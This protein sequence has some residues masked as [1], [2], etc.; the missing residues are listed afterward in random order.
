[1]RALI[2]GCNGFVGRLL[3]AH[4]RAGGAEI[5]GIDRTAQDPDATGAGV[6]LVPGDILDASFVGK[7]LLQARPSHVFH[8]AAVMG[9]SGTDRAGLLDVNAQGTAVVADAVRRHAPGAWLLLASSSAVYGAQ[10]ALPIGEDAPSRPTTP[11]GESKAAAEDAARRVA[12]DGD[13]RLVIARTFNLLGPG[14]SRHLFAGSLAAQIVAAEHGGPSR[15]RVGHLQGKRDYVDV[16][17][18]VR[19]CVSLT[20]CDS[21]TFNVCSEVAR[22]SQELADRMCAHATVPVTLEHDAARLQT[23]DV[24]EQR[25]SFRRLAAATGWAPAI[26]FD[27][28][29][30]DVLEHERRVA[31]TAQ[32]G[33]GNA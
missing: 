7:V 33:R 8:M 29:V 12:A 21:G 31:T 14:M 16:R 4:L 13:I 30:R 10:D 9:T 11:Y 27:Q 19:A 26:S 25:G 6:T 18:A 23:G 22:S 24:D 5:C 1:M 32:A 2:T 15:I 3:V 28:S 20:A 17:D